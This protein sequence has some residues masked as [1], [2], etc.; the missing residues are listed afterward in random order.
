MSKPVLLVGAGVVIA[1]AAAY[2]MMSRDSLDSRPMEAWSPPASVPMGLTVIDVVSSSGQFLWQRLGDATGKAL[3]T[4]NSD[5]GDGK[6][7]CSGECATKFPPLLAEASAVASGDWSIVSREDGTKQW[8]YQGMPLHRY[9][10]E[11]PPDTKSDGSPL[12]GSRARDPALFDPGSRL[13]SPE[14]DWKRAAFA[15]DKTMAIPAGIKLRSHSVA[16]GYVFVVANTGMVIYAMGKPPKEQEVSSWMPVDAPGLAVPMGD[17]SLVSRR[18]DGRRQWAYKGYLLYTYRG[19]YSP[20][21]LNGMNADKGVY[22]A[23]AYANYMPPAVDIRFVT[24]RGPVMMT[25]EG[26]TLY[27]QLGYRLQYGGRLSRDGYS[28]PYADAKHVGTRGCIEAC[29]EKWQPLVAGASDQPSGFWEIET[30]ADNGARQWAYKGA[31]LYT[32]VGDKKAGDLEGNN[33]YVVVYGDV[34]GKV[35][36]SLTTGGDSEGGDRAGSSFYWRSAALVN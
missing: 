30:R 18:A 32:F 21:D 16:N 22:A 31:P 27:T 34:E 15:P 13:Y 12:G 3:Y 29:L 14:D 35:D 6:S 25:K 10:G 5:A 36:L 8:A 7:T 20:T 28:Y 26:R 2:F 4:F 11:D 17:F 19:D 1:A 24:A 23:L 9:S 33:Q